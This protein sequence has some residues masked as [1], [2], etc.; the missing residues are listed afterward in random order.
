MALWVLKQI[1][2]LGFRKVRPTIHWRRALHQGVPNHALKKGVVLYYDASPLHFCSSALGWKPSYKTSIARNELKLNK[3][4]SISKN[5]HQLSPLNE[6]KE[7]EK[8]IHSDNPS[9]SN[10]RK[11]RRWEMTTQ[12]PPRNSNLKKSE[13]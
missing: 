3:W 10:S 5:D 13:K 12:P 11:V 2:G 4:M 9:N 6:S 7:G 1:N 8:W